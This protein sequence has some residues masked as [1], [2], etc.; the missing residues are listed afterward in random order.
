MFNFI[1]YVILLDANGICS[2]GK[3]NSVN[4]TL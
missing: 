4:K 2:G 3:N 1:S